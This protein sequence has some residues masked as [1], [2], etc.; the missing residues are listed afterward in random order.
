MRYEAKLEGYTVKRFDSFRA[1]CEYV[2]RRNGVR[3][4]LQGRAPDLAMLR[5]R[6]LRSDGPHYARTFKGGLHNG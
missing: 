3:R 4:K 6:D 5:V 2:A 1:A